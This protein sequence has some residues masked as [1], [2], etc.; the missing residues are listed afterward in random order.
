MVCV[1]AL[2][3]AECIIILVRRG[4]GMKKQARVLKHGLMA[5]LL[6]VLAMFPVVMVDEAQS[7]EEVE[8]IPFVLETLKADKMPPVF[9]SH[10]KHI[11]AL[12]DD[13]ESCHIDGSEYFLESENKSADEVMAYVHD[14]CV[15]CHAQVADGKPTGPALASCRS[16]HNTD[17]AAKQAAAQ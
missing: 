8:R 3:P 5:A 17:I 11:A 6:A 2:R 4:V 14:A 7:A 13:C 1:C 15:K 9:F 16:C 10:D 12:E